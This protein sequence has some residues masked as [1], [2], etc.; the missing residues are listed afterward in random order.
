[1]GVLPGQIA[2]LSVLG[3]ALPHDASPSYAYRV[4]HYL[5]GG[6][7]SN[8][9]SA[10]DETTRCLSNN[11]PPRQAIPE[12]GRRPVNR[13]PHSPAGLI[14]PFGP[15][16]SFLMTRTATYGPLLHGCA[17]APGRRASGSCRTQTWVY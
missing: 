12:K 6:S 11:G 2:G 5:P 14:L 16:W 17:S 4:R 9:G 1:M 7:Y 10:E 15:F 3:T 8:Q 13:W